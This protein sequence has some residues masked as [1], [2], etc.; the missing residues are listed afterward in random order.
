MHDALINGKS[1]RPFDII[2]DYNR[3][4]STVEIEFILPTR[5]VV[6]SLN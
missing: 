6:R 3:R 4:V 1:F 2:S 5:R